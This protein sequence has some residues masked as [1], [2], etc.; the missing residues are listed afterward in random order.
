MHGRLGGKTPVQAS[1]IEVD[2]V[3]KWKALFKMLH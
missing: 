3:N 2:G 1:F